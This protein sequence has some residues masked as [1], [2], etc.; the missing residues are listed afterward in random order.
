M[1][2]MVN[3]KFILILIGICLFGLVSS[4]EKIAQFTSITNVSNDEAVVVLSKNSWNVD[5]AVLQFFDNPG[6]FSLSK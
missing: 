6:V 4:R 5:V 1:G 2:N 3:N